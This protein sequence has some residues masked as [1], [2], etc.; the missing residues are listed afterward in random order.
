[1]TEIDWPIALPLPSSR[2]GGTTVAPVLSTPMESGRVRQRR[3][4]S[5]IRRVWSVTWDFSL[6]EYEAF[7]AFFNHEIDAGTTYFNLTLPIDSEL[8]PQAVR[9]QGGSFSDQYAIFD[10]MTVSAS[11]ESGTIE[12]NSEAWLYVFVFSGGDLDSYL[13]LSDDWDVLINETLPSYFNGN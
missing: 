7:L 9:F 10:R 6:L 3:R 2:L 11:L 1:M 5:G 13:E 12:T 4:F 8:T